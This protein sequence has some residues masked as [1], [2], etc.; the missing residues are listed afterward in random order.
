MEIHQNDLCEHIKFFEDFLI[1][2]P[3]I[4]KYLSSLG[5]PLSNLNV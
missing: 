5:I 2:S 4:I 3:N 1:L